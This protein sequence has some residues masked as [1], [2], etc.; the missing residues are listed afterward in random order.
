MRFTELLAEYTL[1]MHIKD[2]DAKAVAEAKTFFLDTLG[3]LLAGI[4]EA[5]TAIGL[6]YAE[7]IG[8]K[9]TSSIIGKKG[10]KTDIYNALIINGIAAHVHDYDDVLQPMDGHPSA[11]ILPVALTVGEAVGASGRDALEAYILGVEVCNLLSLAMNKGSRYYSRGWH[12]TSS[13]GVFGA[14]A[15]AGKLL[16]LDRQQLV[17]AFAMAASE[18]SGLK[19]NFGTMTKSLHVGR[20]ASKGFYCAKMALLGYDANPDVMEM[21]EGF[22]FVNDMEIDMAAAENFIKSKS[23][24]FLKPGLTMKPWPCCKQ[25]HSAINS[26]QTLLAKHGF[27]ADEVDSIHCLVQPV[28]NDCLKYSAPVSTLQGKFSLNYNLALA[29][30]YETAGLEHFDGD[31]IM[32]QKVIDFMPKV[33]KEIDM[34]VSGG[35]YSNGR[36]DCIVRVTLRDG[37]VFEERTPHAKG[38]PLSRMSAEE[39]YAKFFDCAKRAVRQDAVKAVYEKVY[40]L[41]AE[42]PLRELIAMLEDAAL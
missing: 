28:I 35:L 39:V 8:E 27:T 13:L 16:G 11:V 30:L 5:P 3:C 34:E 25:N 6:K 17:Y 36:F 22:A 29:A 1:D 33:T 31:T 41:E 7:E 26:V 19:G 15:A 23:S 10:R 38:D 9:H 18:S 24:A 4:N 2:V 32:D 40:A 37:R 14:T 12:S 20:A 42:K 21:K